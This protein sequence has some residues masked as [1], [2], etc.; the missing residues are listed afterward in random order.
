MEF[1]YESS[2]QNL[3]A[4]TS[5]FYKFESITSYTAIFDVFPICYTKWN[6]EEKECKKPKQQTHKPYKSAILKCLISF[7]LHVA[8]MAVHENV[9]SGSLFNDDDILSIGIFRR[10][11]HLILMNVSRDHM[12]LMLL[13]MVF[14]KRGM[15]FR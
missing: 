11:R 13:R 7:S 5:F 15:F 14:E 2:L 9:H 8:I 1:F 6:P 4:T 10:R 12:V 3:S